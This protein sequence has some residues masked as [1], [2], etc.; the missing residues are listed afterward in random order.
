MSEKSAEMVG[1]LHAIYRFPV[2]SMRGESLTES[3]VEWQGL[4]EDRRYAFIQSENH[5]VFPYLTAR[6][7]PDLLH[8][9]PF[10]TEPGRSGRPAL[11]VRTPEGL[12]YPIWSV[13]LRESIAIRY[14]RPFH[15]IRLG[16]TGTFDI[17]P[18]SVMTTST[19]ASLGKAL[20]MTLNPLRF[21]PTILI[22]TPTGDPYPENQWV[23]QTL[24]FGDAGENGLHMLVSEPDPRCTMITLDPETAAAEPR[25]LAEVVQ[26]RHGELGVYG[27]PTRLGTLRVGQP[28]F[29]QRE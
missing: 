28:V 18:L 6:E 2:K 19:V 13:E 10:F 4:P 21:R 25:V 26:S 12:E 29:L 5:T 17:A 14:P 9:T 3:S 8:Y 22:E 20:G 7:I 16:L 27:L 1:I 11:M 23:G 15:L 24:V